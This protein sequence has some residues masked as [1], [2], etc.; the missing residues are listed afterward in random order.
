MILHT[1]YISWHT[2][3]EDPV[4]T[5]WDIWFLSQGEMPKMTHQDSSLE[6]IQKIW[7]TQD[8]QAW[9]RLQQSQILDIKLASFIQAESDVHAKQQVLVLFPDAHWHKCAPVTEEVKQQIIQLFD[10]TAQPSDQ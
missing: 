7:Q 4:E 1:Y 8:V 10:Q 5:P 2:W 6:E 3:R 9:N